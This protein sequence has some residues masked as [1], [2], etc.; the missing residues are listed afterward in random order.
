MLN[1]VP[2][3]LEFV[4]SDVIPDGAVIGITIW[5]PLKVEFS[6]SADSETS[7]KLIVEADSSVMEVFRMITREIPK[8]VL[9]GIGS[10][11]DK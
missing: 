7:D 4:I 6:I 3:N 8:C 9:N 11:N 1:V 10:S 2:M 5:P